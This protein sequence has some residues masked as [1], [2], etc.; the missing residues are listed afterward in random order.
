[1]RVAV[2]RE[3]DT[4]SETER[5][6]LCVGVGWKRVRRPKALR[7]RFCYVCPNATAIY[8]CSCYRY[9][10]PHVCVCARTQGGVKEEDKAEEA[11]QSGV[12]HEQAREAECT[13]SNLGPAVDKQERSTDN[14]L[15][16][17]LSY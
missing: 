11:G 2:L 10:C 4:D 12:K 16:R 5:V 3:T 13:A 6:S 17:C 1:M 14:H 15:R 7:F 8:V 9:M